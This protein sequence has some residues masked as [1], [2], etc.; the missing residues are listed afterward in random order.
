MDSE[1]IPTGNIVVGV[2]GS[3]CADGA[4]AWAVEQE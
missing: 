2:D 3:S 1:R 4:F